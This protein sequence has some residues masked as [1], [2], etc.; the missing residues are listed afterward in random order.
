[1]SAF[2]DLNTYTYVDRPMLGQQAP[3]S[4][5]AS[6]SLDH[7]SRWQNDGLQHFDMSK[8]ILFSFFVFR[9]GGLRTKFKNHSALAVPYRTALAIVISVV[10]VK[11]NGT[12]RSE[13]SG[14]VL[15]EQPVLTIPPIVALGSGSNCSG[16]EKGVISKRIRRVAH[17]FRLTGKNSGMPSNT[18]I[19]D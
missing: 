18:R 7:F 10:L 16:L 6:S 14:Y 19:R 2:A 1:M 9:F 11:E 3:S 4:C 17:S 15:P 12:S 5:A 8:N 13:E